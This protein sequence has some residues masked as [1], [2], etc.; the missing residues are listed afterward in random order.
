ME[1]LLFSPCHAPG[2]TSEVPDTHTKKNTP[3]NEGFSKPKSV[4]AP[5]G[6]CAKP[7]SVPVHWDMACYRMF[8]GSSRSVW[9]IGCGSADRLCIVKRP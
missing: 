4:R 6:N 1:A 5:E 2:K 9:S 7:I 8:A 3:D